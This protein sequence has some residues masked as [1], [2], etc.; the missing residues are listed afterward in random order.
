MLVRSV[1]FGRVTMNNQLPSI[2]VNALQDVV[3][4]ERCTHVGPGDWQVFPRSSGG[5]ANSGAIRF[6][7]T[8]QQCRDGIRE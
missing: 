7:P 2:E 6:F 3:G 5:A 4:G 8:R 1:H